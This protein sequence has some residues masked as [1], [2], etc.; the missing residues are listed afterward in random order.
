MGQMLTAL[1]EMVTR[2]LGTGRPPGDVLQITTAGAVPVRPEYQVMASMSAMAAFPWVRAC[3]LA[4]VD[5][6][7]G[8]PI[9]ATEEL[10]DGTHRQ[11]THPA[12][13]LLR[14]PSTRITG[15]KL[16]RQLLVDYLLTGNAYILLP[17]PALA[18]RAMSPMLRLHP[19]LVE[20]DTDRMGLPTG[21]RYNGTDKYRLDQVLHI[22]DVSW[23]DDARMLLGESAIRALH[24]DL[25]SHKAAKKHAA[26]SAQRGRPDFL[27]TPSGTA[28]FGKDGS[29]KIAQALDKSLQKGDGVIV[30]DKEMQVVPLHLTSRDMEFAEQYQNTVHA[31]LAVFGVPPVRVGLPGANYG[32]AKTQMRAYWESLQHRAAL[33]DDELSRLAGGRVRLE[34]DFTAV[35]AL[36]VSQT[37]RLE[38]VS[39]WVALGF[40]PVSAARF[41]GFINPPTLS[42]APNPADIADRRRPER[43]PE[44]PQ[45]TRRSIGEVL[46]AYMAS[47]SRRYDEAIRAVDYDGTQLGAVHAIERHLLTGEL[48]AHLGDSAPHM[49]AHITTQV[50]EAVVEHL[51]SCAARDVTPATVAGLTAF[52]PT[53]T[54]QLAAA[55][56]AA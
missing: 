19:A 15:R 2:F 10:A 41:E 27:V 50:H 53:W 37:E 48:A 22:A 20:V 52:G 8:L 6:L 32:T 43:E 42:E 4:I 51:V 14:R 35:D 12:L 49:A 1:R 30:A 40:E 25:M 5:D 11:T 23:S 54:R 47:A 28:G 44:E 38:R 29:K 36:Q 46:G 16:R 55:L 56:E 9:I 34:H 24:D 33:F 18:A 17:D 31:I 26:Q 7:S 45:G 39:T 21:Y 13:E 3:V